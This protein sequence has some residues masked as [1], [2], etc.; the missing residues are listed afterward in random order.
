MKKFLP[1]LAFILIILITYF[2]FFSNKENTDMNQAKS[3]LSISA[4][5]LFEKHHRHRPTALARAQALLAA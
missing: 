1:L 3:D 2:L 4:I 5:E